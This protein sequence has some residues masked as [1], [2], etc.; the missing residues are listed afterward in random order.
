MTKIVLIVAAFCL[1]V[2]LWGC[3]TEGTPEHPDSQIGMGLVR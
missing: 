2:G 3:H 1:L